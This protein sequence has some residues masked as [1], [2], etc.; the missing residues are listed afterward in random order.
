M[1]RTK[2]QPDNGVLYPDTLTAAEA[3]DYLNKQLQDLQFA[4]T[5]LSEMLQKLDGMVN[6]DSNYLSGF[7]VEP[8]NHVRVC[9]GL[10]L[11][12]KL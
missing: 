8:T 11:T 4:A 3:Y 2:V 10:K 5:R 6:P 1:A 9:T 7:V 12:M